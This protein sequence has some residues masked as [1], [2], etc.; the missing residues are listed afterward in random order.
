MNTKNLFQ[1]IGEKMRI[2]FEAAA[3]IEHNGSRGTM[4]E[5]ILKKFLSEGRLPPKY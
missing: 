5:N 3:E 2:D 1:K 4:R